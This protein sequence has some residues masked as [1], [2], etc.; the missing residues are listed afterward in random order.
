HGLT[1]EL[2]RLYEANRVTVTRQLAYGT[3]SHK[4]IDMAFLVN[5]LPVATAELK[6]PLTGQNIE[7]AIAQYRTDRDPANVTLAR[8][9]LVH[10]AGAAD[11]VAR[12]TRLAGQAP[13]SLPFTLG[14]GGGAGNPPNPV[15]HRTAYLW[16]RVWARDAWLDILSR[17]IHVE[18]PGTGSP[19][20]RRAA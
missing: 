12:T 11:R 9:A 18:R 1:E 7:H 4:T 16:E 2:R 6:N 15:G 17:F 5:G 20:A 3:G 13:R 14:H 10:F 19:A 8:R